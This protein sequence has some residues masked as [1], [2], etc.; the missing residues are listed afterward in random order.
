MGWT[1]DKLNSN[2]NDNNMNYISRELE[3]QNI[4]NYKE[5]I[6]CNRNNKPL[7]IE[8]QY[9]HLPPVT[10]D[11][12]LANNAKD[13][14]N[15]FHSIEQYFTNTTS[16]KK[17]DKTKK[18]N[19][20]E[21]YHHLRNNDVINMFKSTKNSKVNS[22]IEKF[23]FPESLDALTNDFKNCSNPNNNHSSFSSPSNSGDENNNREPQGK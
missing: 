22:T 21:F 18:Y 1:K 4:A 14:K 3:H 15:V 2:T 23:D 13:H 9:N 19:L 16:Y 12:L 6:S 7:K 17:L 5:F 20:V 10:Q 11:I 8:S